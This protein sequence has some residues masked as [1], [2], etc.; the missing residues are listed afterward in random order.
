MKSKKIDTR[1]LTMSVLFAAGMM[2]GGLLVTQPA[3]A[4]DLSTPVNIAES[5]CPIYQCLPP[6]N[7]PKKPKEP[8]PEP[9]PEPTPT[10]TP[11]PPAPN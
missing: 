6:G 10:P 3:K 5:L 8:E 1:Y 9:D 11:E 4:L 2:A 7:G